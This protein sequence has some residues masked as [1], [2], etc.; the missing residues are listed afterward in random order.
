MKRWLTTAFAHR[1]PL[2]F[3]GGALLA[4]GT[5]VLYAEQQLGATETEL[6][7]LQQQAARTAQRLAELRRAAAALDGLV[8]AAP[9]PGDALTGIAAARGLTVEAGPERK[10]AAERWR[11]SEFH[12]HGALLHEEILLDILDRWS[13]LSA[14]QHQVRHCALRRQAAE[15]LADCRLA[16]LLPAGPNP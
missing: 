2:L 16:L 5:A 14:F 4:G 6:A 1:L 15:L 7:A 12:L 9:A 3:C 13:R 8:V 10:T 11:A